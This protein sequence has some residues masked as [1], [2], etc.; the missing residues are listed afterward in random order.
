MEL[1]G[2][3][4]LVTGAS[5]GI[6][7]SIAALLAT[8]GARLALVARSREGL[9]RLAASVRTGGGAAVAIPWDL[10]APGA[11]E[12]LPPEVERLVGP[13]D[14]LVNNAGIEAYGRFD[15]LDVEV[16]SR[17]LYLNL[18]VPMRLTRGVLGGMRSRGRGHVVNVSSLAGLA[19]RAHGEAYCASKHGLVG[20]TR[21][22][23]ASLKADQIGRAH[24]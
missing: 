13:V 1:A 5:R 19:A 9:D 11:V 10:A 7:T 12:G 15:E 6:G 21:S 20:F 2:R 3:T 17:I 16:T 4:V 22:L 23:R 18:E 24:V 14:V 8:R